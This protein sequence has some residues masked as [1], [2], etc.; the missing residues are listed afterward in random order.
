M[1]NLH[2]ISI[3]SIFI[4]TSCKKDE[5]INPV[6]NNI[7]FISKCSEKDTICLL[8]EQKWYIGYYF[9]KLYSN[10]GN[11]IIWDYTTRKNRS[12]FYR[13]IKDST[14]TTNTIL[15]NGEININSKYD[16]WKLKK[17]SLFLY[18]Y[19]PKSTF[20]EVYKKYNIVKINKDSLVYRLYIVENENGL[21]PY[22]EFGYGH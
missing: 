15:S 2:I 20:L 21:H 7:P 8:C 10:N 13:F 3:L 14:Y 1:K 18:K 17:D 5:I 12:W 16:S 22:Y 4:I 19:I 6:I 9:Q 11:S